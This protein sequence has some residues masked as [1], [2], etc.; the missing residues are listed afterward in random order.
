MDNTTAIIT[1][2]IVAVLLGFCAA[3][4]VYE[5]RSLEALSKSPDPVAF[6]CAASPQHNP[7]ACLALAARNSWSTK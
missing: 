7:N 6:A 3:V 4:T 5:L 1:A 2:G